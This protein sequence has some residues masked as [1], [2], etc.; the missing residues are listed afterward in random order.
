M[1]PEDLV[2]RPDGEAIPVP[3]QRAV[4]HVARIVVPIAFDLGGRIV[5]YDAARSVLDSLTEGVG[6]TRDDIP[7]AR[8]WNLSYLAEHPPV[9]HRDLAPA[10]VTFQGTTWDYT[11]SVRIYGWLGVL[12]VEYQFVARQ[13][14]ADVA[15]FYDA[16][17]EWKNT[18]YLPYLHGEGALNAHIVAHT[19]WKPSSGDRDLHRTVVCELRR[20]MRHE[21]ALELRASQYAF[22]DCRPCFVVARS[23]FSAQERQGWLFLGGGADASQDVERAVWRNAHVSSTGWSTVVAV[24]P[25]SEG[26]TATVLDMLS[27]VHAQ[28]FLCQ[29][30]SAHTRPTPRRVPIAA[31]PSE[32]GNAP[33]PNSRWPA[34]WSRPMIWTTC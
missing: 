8:S 19:G 33:A 16:F 18:D 26:N 32:R 34:T 12:T 21:H 7:A 29:S 30:G 3:R 25:G 23:E 4:R 10:S 15:S 1:S 28:W 6:A 2:A 27:L 22:H 11:R 24:G 9:L 20:R 13:A 31:H 17:V 5:D 14:G